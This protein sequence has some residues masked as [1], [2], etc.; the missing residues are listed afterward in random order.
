MWLNGT[1]IGRGATYSVTVNSFLAT[2]GDNFFA[3]AGGTGKQDTGQTDLR[4]D[5][6][7]HGRVR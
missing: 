6:R 4:G 2:G 5:G 1:P 3:F 7:L